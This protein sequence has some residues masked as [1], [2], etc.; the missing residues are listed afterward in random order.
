MFTVFHNEHGYRRARWD[1][2]KGVCLDV[3]PKIA[4]IILNIWN[5][6]KIDWQQNFWTL[7]FHM[8]ILWPGWVS[9]LILAYYIYLIFKF[10]AV[11]PTL[12]GVIL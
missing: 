7:D 6:I 12:N 2:L 5:A 9:G 11:L 4:Y 3:I 10:D 1:G 8:A